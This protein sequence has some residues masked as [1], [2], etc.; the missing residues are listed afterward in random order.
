MFKIGASKCLPFSTQMMTLNLLFVQKEKKRG[1]A[2]GKKKYYLRKDR[3][4]IA[5]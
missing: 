2:G 5:G 4:K 1:K 3:G